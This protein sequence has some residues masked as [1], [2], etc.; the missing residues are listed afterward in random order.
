MIKL[1]Y[2]FCCVAYIV[3]ATSCDSDI[4]K[5]YVNP[6]NGMTLYGGTDD[7]L[8]KAE[9][10]ESL[11]LTLYWD[12]STSL[13]T[14]DNDIQSPV[15]PFEL[16]LQL[17]NSDAFDNLVEVALDKGSTSRQFLCGE[18]N[19]FLTRLDFS[20][21]GMQPLYIRLKSEL[22]AN[23][24]PAYSNLL[25]VNVQ[26]FKLNMQS[27]KV[28]AADKSETEIIL[29]SPSENGIY[30]GFMGV[31]AW[32]NWWFLEANDLLWGNNGETGV[33][34]EA[35]P[36][37][38]HWNFW[39]PEDAGCYY[40]T[41][42]TREMWWS[43]LHV[44][45]LTISGDITGDMVYNQKNN[46][47]ALTVDKPAGNYKV[48]INGEGALYN[49]TTDTYRVGAIPVSVGFTDNNKG[50]EFVEGEGKEIQVN[51]PGGETSLILDLT[52]P[53]EFKLATGEAPEPTESPEEVLWMS[54]FDDGITGEWNFNCYLTLYDEN[55]NNYAG[56]HLADSLWGWLLYTDNNWGGV[57]GTDSSDP[58]SGDIVEGGGNIPSPEPGR[59]LINVSLN[60]KTYTLNKVSEVWYSGLN[61][62]WELYP[63]TL[64]DGCIYEAEVE[65]YADTPWG[66]K[67]LLRDDWSL[68]FG[69]ADGI[70][71]YGWDGFNGANDLP[72]GTYILR[73]DLSKCIYTFI[74][75]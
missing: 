22:A 33:P 65:K 73:V 61:D 35:S 49:T 56:V 53:F 34:F 70:L 46:S 28:L 9:A 15:N 42:N 37:E 24:N 2:I 3:S 52:N 7:I 26:P 31:A 44:D 67:I 69:G 45:K 27:G 50:L 13:T 71:R 29:A 16:T 68:W 66:V 12:S 64:V 14:S 21:D 57:M 58:Y 54:G 20:A 72:D 19:A 62:D 4:T 23:L 74:E 25:Q 63:M 6:T 11:A 39:F 36:N 48:V 55:E 43:A 41:L 59:Y 32:Y 1:F 38:S 17:S 40:V 18:L 47:W 51:L 5:V 8:L 30:T 75:K 60:Q 10:T